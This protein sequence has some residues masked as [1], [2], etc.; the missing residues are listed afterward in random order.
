MLFL[1]LK[2]SYHSIENQQNPIS[3]MYKYHFYSQKYVLK[4]TFLQVFIKENVK[5]VGLYWVVPFEYE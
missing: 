1:I 2:S 4:K 5:T 3:S